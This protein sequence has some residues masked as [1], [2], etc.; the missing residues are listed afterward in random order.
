MKKLL[1]GSLIVAIGLGIGIGST[2]VASANGRYSAK[3]SN[4][5]RLIW[6]KSMKQHAFT[7]TRGYRYSKHLGMRYTRNAATSSTTWY[8]DAHEKFYQKDRHNY[9]IYY[10]VHNA[11]NTL[12]GWT[13]RGYLQPVKPTQ[14][15]TT[16]AYVT[17]EKQQAQTI[18]NLFTGVVPDAQL[19]KV[20]Q[21]FVTA[22]DD[23][24][25]YV[26]NWKSCLNSA[27]FKASDYDKVRLLT[28]QDG[29]VTG[30]QFTNDYNAGKLTLS[31]YFTAVAMQ[32]GV[33]IPG[34]DTT[35]T[36]NPVPAK[37]T[38]FKGWHIGVAAVDK[39]DSRDMEVIPPVYYVAL[40]PAKDMH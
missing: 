13:W 6:R 28:T 25:T 11:A 37:Y 35:S 29:S 17:L 23:G 22:N 12:Q 7:A 40:I 34:S 9:A 24:E 8:T 33:L 31:Q 19:T 27:G 36:T 16:P 21:K 20:V 14:A 1:Q 39:S 3:R 30:E 15:K 4:S 26:D 38:D 5:V 2:T 10:H 32:N 18:I